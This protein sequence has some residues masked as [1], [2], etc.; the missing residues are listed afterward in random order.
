MNITL[1]RQI[2]VVTGAAGVLC[3]AMS[4]AV[5]KCGARVVLLGRTESKLEALQQA[6]KEK[7][8]TETLVVAADVQSREDLEAAKKK[9]NDTWGKVSLLINGAGGNR[10]EATSQKEILEANDSLEGSFFDIDV[11]AFMSVID[12]NFKGSLLPSFIFAKDMLDQPNASVINI[13]SMSAD[14]PLTKVGAYSASKATVDNFT[15]WLAVHLAKKNI[16][17]N[18]IAPGFFATQQNKFLLYEQDQVTLTARGNKIV[19]NT[20]MG[21]FGSPED[22]E[23]AV[24]FLASPLAKFI[25]GIVLPV[26]G[27]FS[28]YSGV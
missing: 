9:I 2:C 26:D 16:R 23:G 15:K 3:S 13:S 21:S 27:G 8:Y 17:V 10:P 14:R 1:D 5:L 28:A 24:A 18:A 7:G 12:L 25:T 19:S 22:L 4:E 11:D 20:P 6:F